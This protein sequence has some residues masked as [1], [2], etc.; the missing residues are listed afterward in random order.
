MGLDVFNTSGNGF[1]Y[2]ANPFEI[3]YTVKKISEL[4][5]S[6]VDL[7]IRDT[8]TQSTFFYDLNVQPAQTFT[9]TGTNAYFGQLLNVQGTSSDGNIARSEFVTFSYAAAPMT[10]AVPEP[11]TIWFAAAWLVIGTAGVVRHRLP[12]SV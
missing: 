9:F 12:A 5:W 6:V 10:H 3:D 1:D 7:T 4:Q 11:S 2:D 8:V